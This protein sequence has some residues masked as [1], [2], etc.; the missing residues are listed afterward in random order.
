MKN[1]R[2]TL[3]SA[4]ALAT[5]LTPWTAMA[6]S[7]REAPF[8]TENPKV[9][10]T[11]FYMFRSYE[12]TA[13][14][15]YVTL[16][17]N[18]IPAQDPAGGP[19]FYNM[20]PDALYEIHV[21]NTGDGVEDL[22]FQFDFNLALQNA[23]NGITLPI[24]PAGS[25]MD[26]AIPIVQAGGI[27]AP[28][29]ATQNVL[30]TYT[31]KLVRGDRRT[32][33]ASTEI[34]NLGTSGSGTGTSFN[35]PVDNIGNK[36]IPDYAAY[37][38]QFVQQFDVPGC[39]PTGVVAGSH[40]RVFVGQR[41]EG[42]AVNLGQIFDLLNFRASALRAAEVVPDGRADIAPAMENRDQGFNTLAGKNVTTIAVEVPASC[43]NKPA[44]GADPAGTIIAGWT[45]ASLRQARVINPTASFT[46]PAR[47]GGPWAQ[48]SR[49]GMP[50][51]NEVVIGLKD[52]N[53]FNGSEPKDDGQ[54][55]AYV[56]NPTLPELA[57]IA[58]GAQGGLAPTAFPRADLVV[59]FLNGL[60]NAT[61]L[62]PTLFE[63]V[64]LNTNVAFP[65][66]RR[67][68]QVDLGAAGCFNAPVDANSAPVFNPA[69][70][71]CDLQGFPNGRRPGDDVVDI[72][73]RVAM[74]YLLSPNQA[75]A[76]SVPFTD[77][78][79][80]NAT[81]FQNAFPYLNNPLPGSP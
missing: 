18:Y 50:L 57:E 22:T 3:Q 40:S 30:E 74:G 47:E 46:V 25:T 56:T 33:T 13:R 45:T 58:L 72:E 42:F 69:A 4:L 73:L 29:A 54:F 53:K 6:S 20:D 19:N 14:D 52:K 35:K 38:A 62:G 76:R 1:L 10:G 78:A 44:A 77:G 71:G 70:L 24:G 65:I 81:Q 26:V 66:T 34:V 79:G 43:L 80:V 31:V 7:H 75:P 37:S 28:N 63:A 64:R 12:G 15:G 60:P 48:V 11:D 68:N 27:T 17:A 21:D 32:G 8:I 2:K 67:A 5:V 16:L 49:V 55:A 9:D 61:S 39:T 36:T 41:K 59:A 51:V 23:G